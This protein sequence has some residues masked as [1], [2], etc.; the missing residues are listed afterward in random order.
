MRHDWHQFTWKRPTG[1]VT[2]T[3]G[4]SEEKGAKEKCFLV[5]TNYGVWEQ[6][7]GDE[8]CRP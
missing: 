8:S 7:D 1:G 2:L 3:R 5:P 4:I 6:Y